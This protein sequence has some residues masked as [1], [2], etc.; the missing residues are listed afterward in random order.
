MKK[1]PPKFVSEIITMAVIWNLFLDNAITC[2]QEFYFSMKMIIM[3]GNPPEN[4][5]T[6]CINCEVSIE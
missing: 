1:K 2:E 4:Y 5:Y 3:Y 6:S